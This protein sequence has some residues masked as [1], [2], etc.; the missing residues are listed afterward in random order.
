MKQTIVFTGAASF[1]MGFL[2]AVVAL[3]IALAGTVGAQE[4]R[5]RAEQLTVVGD[6]GAD[7]V[8]IQT[9]P[10]EASSVRLLDTNGNLRSLWSTLGQTRGDDPDAA[11][12]SFQ[13]SSG[14]Q[15]IRLGTGRGPSSTG[16][17]EQTLR[18]TD[19]EG[20]IR[21][22]IQVAEDGSP[23]ISLLDA[24]GNVTWSAP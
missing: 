4:T 8:R 10:G 18:L 7:R 9:G 14:T 16:P 15:V 6:N 5:L 1:V 23:S 21:A 3:V 19:Q 17:L 11:G 22:L 20:R 2:G 12:I 13:N 24:S